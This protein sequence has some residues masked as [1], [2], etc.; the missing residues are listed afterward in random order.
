MWLAGSLWGLIGG[1]KSVSQSV[2]ARKPDTHAPCQARHVVDSAVWMHG[3]DRCVSRLFCELRRYVLVPQLQQMISSLL[4]HADSH[5]GR[6]F[7][8]RADL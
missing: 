1:K 3:G 6:N 8:S 5:V 7:W 4:G 2:G